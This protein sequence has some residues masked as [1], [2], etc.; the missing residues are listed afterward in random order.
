VKSSSTLLLVL[1]VA[2]GA[3]RFLYALTRSSEGWTGNTYMEVVYEQQARSI[4]QSGE[5]EGMKRRWG[6]LFLLLMNGFNRVFS[7]PRTLRVALRLFLVAAYLVTTY[8]LSR[9]F[10]DFKWPWPERER[11]CRRLLVMLLCFQST[12]AIYAISNGSETISALCV[13]GH[14]YSFVR[15]QFLAAALLIWVGVY[16]KLHPIVFAFPYFVFSLLSA[17]HRKYSVYM[18]LSGL[19]MACLSLPLAGWRFGFFYPFSMMHSATTDSALVPLLSKEV[20]GPAFL[21]GRIIS[22]FKVLGVDPRAVAA[23]TTIA[24]IWTGLLVGST[25][26]AAIV[27]R[28]YEKVWNVGS[29]RPAG[30]LVFQS[31]IGFLMFSFSL[32]VSMTLLLPFMISFYSPLWLVA[33][34]VCSARRTT[35]LTVATLG[36]FVVGLVL[37]GNLIPLSL[38]FKV[39]PLAWLDRLAGNSPAELIAIEKYVWYQIPMIGVYVLALAFGGSVLSLRPVHDTGPPPSR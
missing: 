24:S 37:I 18:I 2:L 39:L 8:L 28:T 27:L 17:G 32:D 7:N 3:A 31:V 34:P 23:I 26:A 21:V 35:P 20:F 36:L 9:L 33:A 11:D 19:L 38:L 4:D 13:I 6:P 16:F 10:S 29:R 25:L 14:F 15:K 12:A 5:M 22:S 1:L 30:L